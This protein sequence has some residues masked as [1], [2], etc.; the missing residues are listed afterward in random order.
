MPISSAC[1][2]NDFRLRL[3]VYL[4][5]LPLGAFTQVQFI[6]E[7][8]P[9]NTPE[10][11]SLFI[12][13]NFNNWDPGNVGYQLYLNSEGKYQIS[14]PL[15]GS[16]QFKF[17]RGDW[18]SVEGSAGGGEIANRTAQVSSG[19]TLRLQVL[20]WK[21]IGG[22][23][24]TAL[25]TVQILD[26]QFFIPGLNTT[27]RIW[28]CLPPDYQTNT[29]QHYPVVYMQ[30]GQN[31][32]DTQRA[33]L[34]QEWKVDETMKEL[35]E[36][37]D[38]GAIV[39][40][41]ENGGSSRIAEYTPW[42]NSSYES[43]RGGA[44]ASFIAEYLKPY[45]DSTFRTLPEPEFNAVMGSSLGGLIS[46]YT[47]L[48]YP[49]VFAR[50]GVFSPAYWINKEDLFAWEGLN[51]APGIWVYQLVGN[52]ES[53]SM[54]SDMEQ[55]HELLVEKGIDDIYSLVVP[56][57]SHNEQ[58]WASVYG[59]VYTWLFRMRLTK[60]AETVQSASFLVYPSPFSTGFTVRRPLNDKLNIQIYD[61]TGR[62]VMQ[63]DL[64]VGE[65][66]LDTSL[67]AGIYMIQAADSNG[68][69]WMRR[70]VCRP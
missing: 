62:C 43:G 57:A 48:Q 37:G 42:E 40:G 41:I 7:S 64:G 10:N 68:K 11:P 39:V 47:V 17:T 28:V 29:S 30:D 15:E 51:N 44:Y 2:L 18:N 65:N 45:V 31:L 60:I 16:I 1:I 36:S 32:F 23:G 55:M 67:P 63:T 6:L 4:L 35:F 9:A 24:G 52:R 49:N 20:S 70:I 22:T 50:A 34:G 27:R 21:D 54:V 26:N 8:I 46:L 12:A 56:G 3:L 14:L 13:G 69:R 58:F 5:S 25:P 19:Q 66:R 53:A 61:M 33:F 59:Q 38:S